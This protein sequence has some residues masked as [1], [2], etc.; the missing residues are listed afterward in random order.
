MR[1]LRS[2]RH[3]R[4]VFSAEEVSRRAGTTRRGRSPDEDNEIVNQNLWAL[5]L[6]WVEHSVT[7][8]HT[9]TPVEHITVATLHY[10]PLEI[11]SFSPYFTSFDKLNIE[12]RIEN[13]EHRTQNRE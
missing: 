9:R 1:E 3:T 13:T 5:G 6:A 2:V 8:H 4:R 10:R 7:L 12:H 11:G